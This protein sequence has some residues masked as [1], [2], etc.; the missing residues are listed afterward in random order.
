MAEWIRSSLGDAISIKHGFAFRGEH[1]SDTGPGPMLVTPGNFASGGGFKVG[2]PKYYHGPVPE[3]YDLMAGDLIVSMTDLSKFGDALGS[4]A[5]V[6]STDVYLHNQRVGLVRIEHPELLHT[7]FL[8]YALQTSSFHQ[9]M[10][11]TATGSTV[12]HTSPKRICDYVLACPSLVTQAAIAEVLGAL[13]DKIAANES[14]SQIAWALAESQYLR[15]M[16][17]ANTSHRL[18]EIIELKYGK[19]LPTSAR[20]QG[21]IPVYG[22]GG[23]VG[24][25][26]QALV[27]GPG[28]IVGRKGTAGAVHWS[29]DA[30]YPIDTTFYV[31]CRDPEVPMEFCFFLLR[32]LGLDGMNS[33]SAVPGLN[34]TNAVSLPVQLPSAIALNGFES[35]VRP[36]F[37]L[38]NAKQVES[39]SLAA[40]RDLL[41][42]KLMSGEL[43]VKDTEKAVEEGT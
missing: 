24:S 20:E 11:A 8:Y 10:L 16:A 23:I 22:S 33:D 19:A 36:L 27:Q 9:H 30:F 7:R 17:S 38:V 28:I 15:I 35:T 12:R 32:S 25:H 18:G 40:F 43:R 37:Q 3:G 42:P 2:K 31:E 21:D 13:D 26:A 4:P 29:M 41:L 6:P 34:R 5:I 39:A 14:L 1:F